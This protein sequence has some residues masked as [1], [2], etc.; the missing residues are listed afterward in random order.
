MRPLAVTEAGWPRTVRPEALELESEPVAFLPWVEATAWPLTTSAVISPPKSE[1]P[2]A[3]LVALAEAIEPMLLCADAVSEPVVA[4]EPSAGY[5]NA[6]PNAAW[7]GGAET[8]PSWAPAWPG[9][10]TR[11]A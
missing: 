1:T 11:I 5:E 6:S 2:S 3:W 7:S 8:D 4:T 9:T 10:T